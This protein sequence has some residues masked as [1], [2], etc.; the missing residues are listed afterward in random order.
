MPEQREEV[1]AQKP[2]QPAQFQTQ[3][4][5][6]FAHLQEMFARIPLNIGPLKNRHRFSRRAW[7][8]KAP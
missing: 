5:R 8:E 7:S 6:G 4:P 3:G 2:A 1:A